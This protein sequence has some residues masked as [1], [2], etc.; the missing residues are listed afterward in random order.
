[1]RAAVSRW[2]VVTTKKV[3]VGLETQVPFHSKP[4]FE[5]F[6]RFLVDFAPDRLVGIGDHL[7][8]PAPARWNRGTAAEYATN[9]QYEIDTLKAMFANIRNVYDGPFELHKGNH[10]QRIEAYTRTKA[11]AFSDLLCLSMPELLD[12]RGF[13]LVDLPRFAPLAPGWVT[14]HGDSGG[15]SKF[16]G[17]VA[18]GLAH[19][20]GRSVVCGHTHKLGHIQESVGVGASKTLHAIETG[21][22]MDVKKASY[23]AHESPN[24]QMGWAAFEINGTRVH[25]HLVGCTPTGRLTFDG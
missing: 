12:Y 10:E 16:S 22:M 23:I 20:Q 18:M 25:T 13:D 24:W 9:L 3:V 11:P 17:G 14:T 15:S 19:R 8:C 21:H 6:L 4:A 5:A 2:M 1:M 7:D